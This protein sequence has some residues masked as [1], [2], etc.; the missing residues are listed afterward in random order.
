M[1]GVAGRQTI[2][3][4][5][6]SGPDGPKQGAQTL[7]AITGTDSGVAAKG[8]FEDLPK[9]KQAPAIALANKLNKEKD[10]TVTAKTVHTWLA[11]GKSE[12]EIRDLAKK[13]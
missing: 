3:A 6:S 2:A 8:G 12:A 11:S 5:M 1:D 10:I 4:L 7:L 9:E 13:V